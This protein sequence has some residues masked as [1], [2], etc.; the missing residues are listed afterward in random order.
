VE[1]TSSLSRVF[2]GACEAVDMYVRQRKRKTVN[3]LV[4]KEVT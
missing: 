4:E 1:R 2:Q 3:S